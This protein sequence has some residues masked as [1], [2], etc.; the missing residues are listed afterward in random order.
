MSNIAAIIMG[1]F[2]AI[3]WLVG[4]RASGY[5][6]PLTY[7]IP[8]LVTSL[9]AVAA[10]RGRNRFDQVSPE[11][12]ARRGRLVGIASGVEGLAI[13]L[14]VNVLANLGLSDYAAPV[15]AI[16]VG[17]HFVPLAQWLPAH[18]YYGTGALLIVLGVCGFAIRPPDQRLL[19]VSVGAACVLWLTCVIV[20]GRARIM[21]DGQRDA[22][23]A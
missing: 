23:A 12:H 5:A 7:G 15:I 18:L 11:E 14:A 1:V 22:P 16:I 4:V 3:W 9:I 19:I 2:A 8:L 17:L 6:S 20:L 10:L 13:L 21:R